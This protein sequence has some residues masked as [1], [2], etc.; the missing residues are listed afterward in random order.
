[1]DVEGPNNVKIE[2]VKNAPCNTKR[3]L[4]KIEREEFDKYFKIDEKF[5]NTMRPYV[6]AEE[7]KK[8]EKAK[9]SIRVNCPK[10]GVDI[11]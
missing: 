2:L 6:S 1:M 10:C 11:L 7:A 9:K 5:V 4:D 3:E 8:E